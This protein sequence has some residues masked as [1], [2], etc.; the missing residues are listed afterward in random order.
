MSRHSVTPPLIC[1]SSFDFIRISTNQINLHPEYHH[2]SVLVFDLHT[3]SPPF[4]EPGLTESLHQVR[5]KNL[6]FSTNVRDAI[7]RSQ[8]VLIAVNT[9]PKAGSEENLL[10]PPHLQN[11]VQTL[12]IAYSC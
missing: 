7:S 8:I 6:N 2:S 10:L 5:G 3:P 1:A 4:Y 9:P 11:E 12:S